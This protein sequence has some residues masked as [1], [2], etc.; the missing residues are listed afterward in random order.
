MAKLVYIP[1]EDGS[2]LVMDGD[3]CIGRLMPEVTRPMISVPIAVRAHKKISITLFDGGE[4]IAKFSEHWQRNY[5]ETYP[6][7]TG[8]THD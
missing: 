1:Q 8:D 3:N 2:K 6:F 4:S 5:G 7:A